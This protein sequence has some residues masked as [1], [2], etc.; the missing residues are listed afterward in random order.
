MTSAQSREAETDSLAEFFSY[1]V[2]KEWSDGLPVIPPTATRVEQMIGGLDPDRVLGVIPPRNGLATVRTVAAN[3]VMAGCLPEY[4]PVVVAAIEAA[5]DPRFWLYGLIPTTS[6]GGIGVLVSGPVAERIG[7]NGGNMSL[8]PG[9]RAN[10]TIGRAVRLCARNIGGGR[11]AN[12]DM[13]TQGSPNLISLCFAES[14]DSPWPSYGVERGGM[15]PGQSSVTVFSALSMISM[16]DT[17]SNDPYQLLRSFVNALTR[18]STTNVL[19]GNGPFAVL[20]PEHARVLSAAGF[21]RKDV[22]RFLY[23]HVRVPLAWFNPENVREYVRK[24]RPV[25]AYSEGPDARIPM[26]Q[27]PEEFHVVVSGGPGSHSHVISSLS[28]SFA[29]TKAVGA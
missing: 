9:F 29:V 8:G 5:C 24:R 2:E 28:E 1:A 11:P 13:T 27:S 3:A 23:E 10:M 18:I 22:E 4:F 17:V 15:T 6:P 20:C 14:P 16:F 21:T 26:G 19:I 7:V 25:W 12:G